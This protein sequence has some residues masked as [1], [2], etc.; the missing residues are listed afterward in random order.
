MANGTAVLPEKSATISIKHKN[1]SA[2][3][4]GV[5]MNIGGISLLLGSDFLKQFGRIQIEYKDQ[6]ALLSLG[7]AS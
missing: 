5:V 3:V 1:G 2:T 7:D 4:Q 6:A